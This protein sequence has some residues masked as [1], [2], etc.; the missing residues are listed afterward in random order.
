[1]KED[2][3]IGKY[4]EIRTITEERFGD[5]HS[6]FER[7]TEDHTIIA[8][9]KLCALF[10]KICH[11]YGLKFVSMSNSKSVLSNFLIDPRNLEIAF[12]D[13]AKF[14]A[15]EISSTEILDSLLALK[16]ASCTGFL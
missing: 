5:L 14:E 4:V 13:S 3:E 15:Y 10:H 9:I 12:C 2:R 6:F 1:M 8:V 16:N 7:D 11:T